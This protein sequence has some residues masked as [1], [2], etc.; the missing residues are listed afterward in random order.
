MGIELRS[1]VG[2]KRQKAN[3]QINLA[4]GRYKIEKRSRREI[5]KN[6]IVI[7]KDAHLNFCSQGKTLAALIL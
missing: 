3:G 6:I 5:R 1:I 7:V 4:N 2:A